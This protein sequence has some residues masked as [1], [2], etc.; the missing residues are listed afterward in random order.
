MYKRHLPYMEKQIFRGV[1][2]GWY[3]GYYLD[4]FRPGILMYPGIFRVGTKPCVFPE[5]LMKNSFFNKASRENIGRE[6][7]TEMKRSGIEGRS[8]AD[9]RS[10]SPRPR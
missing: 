1:Q 10:V 4:N 7:A 8:T 5:S 2:C 6:P 3:R 9:G